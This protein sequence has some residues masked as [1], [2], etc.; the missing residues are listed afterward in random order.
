MTDF[1]IT[2]STEKPEARTIDDYSVWLASDI[3]EATVTDP[4]SGSSHT[5]YEY[6][7][8]QYS[9][10]EYIAQLDDQTTALQ[11]ALCSVYEATQ[12]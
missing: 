12:A 3:K 10:D 5:E 8:Q 1:G 9:K 2:R 11:E 7:L 4:E 6:T